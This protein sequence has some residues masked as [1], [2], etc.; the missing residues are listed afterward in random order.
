MGGAILLIQLLVG[1]RKISRPKQAAAIPAR[2]TLS[3]ATA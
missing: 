1:E 2:N 3:E